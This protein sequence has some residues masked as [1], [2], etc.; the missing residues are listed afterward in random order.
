VKGKHIW[1][2][3]LITL[4]ALSF[5]YI[6]NHFV[7]PVRTP[8]FE[9]KLK[10]A[11]LSHKAMESIKQEMIARSI[12]RD[13]INDP[14]STFLVGTKFS[15]ITTGYN[16]LSDVLTTLNPNFAAAFISLFH[17]LKIKKGDIVAVNTSAS[18]PGLNISLL[19]ACE[20]YGI[21]PVITTDV[22]S[23]SYGA[24][25][26][27][28]TYLDMEN[29][30]T[31]KGI[32]HNHS[33]A[34]SIGGEK[35]NGEGLSP[36][37]RELLRSKVEENNIKLIYTGSLAGNIEERFSVYSD[38]AAA[39]KKRLRAFIEVG[40]TISGF[41]ES[42]EDSVI[43]PGINLYSATQFLSNYGLL[44]RMVEQRT[45][46]IYLGNIEKLARVLGVSTFHIPQ[47]KPGEDSLF[48][49]ERYSVKLAILF[50]VLLI[51]LL[52]VYLRIEIILRKR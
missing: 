51:G 41:G 42:M 2:F 40:G 8:F 13:S 25:N 48:F 19:S 52:L 7:S 29:L 46:I 18:F 23:A 34:A 50:L 1:L 21:I 35:D 24:N 27:E 43:K 37:G 49:E 32:F 12:P 22:S 16:P 45:P 14:N 5:F 9:E 44:H 30:L 15:E 4:F 28:F 26:P 11:Q 6:E 10:A 33:I 36:R 17:K 38:F 31:K 39:H 47:P 3:L 20:T